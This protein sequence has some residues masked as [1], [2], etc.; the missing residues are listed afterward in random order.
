M[1][2]VN[3]GFPDHHVIALYHAHAEN[4]QFPSESKT[5]IDLEQFPFG[6]FATNELVLELA[7]PAYSIL[8]DRRCDI[9]PGHPMRHPVKRRHV[10]TVIKNPVM[11]ACYVTRHA[12]MSRIGLGGRRSEKCVC[13]SACL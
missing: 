7:M 6:K 3:V 9:S 4:E 10:G 1:W 2:D 8:H 12:R 5:N 13:R 11:M